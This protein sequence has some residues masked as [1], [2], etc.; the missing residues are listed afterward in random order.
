MLKAVLLKCPARL[1][2]SLS[3]YTQKTSNSYKKKTK[4]P[5]MLLLGFVKSELNSV[6]LQ[7][8]ELD[9]LQI[10]RLQYFSITKVCK[11]SLF[12]ELFILKSLCLV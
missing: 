2:K 12:V 9:S 6:S 4:N 7:V 1:Y 3:Y 8:A 10:V 11:T 5:K